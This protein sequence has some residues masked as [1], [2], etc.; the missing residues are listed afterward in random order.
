L[1]AVVVKK[2]LDHLQEKKKIY[3]YILVYQFSD[4]LQVRT[5]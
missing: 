2:I 3:I 4:S 1:L 5:P